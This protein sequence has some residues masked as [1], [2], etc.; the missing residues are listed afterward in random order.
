MEVESKEEQ[1]R[2]LQQRQSEMQVWV[3]KVLSD[4][5]PHAD[6]IVTGAKGYEF[7]PWKLKEKDFFKWVALTQSGSG[8]IQQRTA[9]MDE[10]L[11]KYEQDR[12]YAKR[13]QAVGGKEALKK[14]LINKKNDKKVLG[15]IMFDGC[16]DLYNV[17]KRSGWYRRHEPWIPLNNDGTFK[18]RYAWSIGSVIDTSYDICCEVK[19]QVTLCKISDK[20]QLKKVNKYFKEKCVVFNK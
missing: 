16:I 3:R 15:F 12:V 8:T 5:Q 7:R 4:W 6:G 1:Q 14:L 19:G 2:Q 17:S 20:D 9:V 11:A 10:Y 13:I 18:Y